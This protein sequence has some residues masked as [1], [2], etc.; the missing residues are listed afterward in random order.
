LAARFELLQLV[1][2]AFS[3]TRDVVSARRE[4][5]SFAGTA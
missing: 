2:G 1:H 5:F 3:L 4:R